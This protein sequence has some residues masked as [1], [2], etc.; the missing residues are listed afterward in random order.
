[1]MYQNKYHRKKPE[2][3]HKY[4]TRRENELNIPKIRDTSFLNLSTTMYGVLPHE[5]KTLPNVHLFVKGVKKHIT[6]IK[7]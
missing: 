1:M 6:S 5:V 7:L 2:K 3:T 4:N